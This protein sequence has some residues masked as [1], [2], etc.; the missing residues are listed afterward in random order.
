MGT[1]E[2][3][4]LLR[5]SREGDISG[6]GQ[7]RAGRGEGKRKLGGPERLLRKEAP[8]ERLMFRERG[9]QRS[10]GEVETATWS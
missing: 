7:G 3:E 8:R 4:S 5:M 6:K 2:F 10:L 1:C 9:T